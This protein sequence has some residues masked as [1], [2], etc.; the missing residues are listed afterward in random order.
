MRKIL[1]L[2]LVLSFL[3]PCFLIAQKKKLQFQSVNQFAITAGESHANTALQTVNGLKFLNYFTGI[4]V[5]LDYYRYK[6]VP[7]FFD[8]KWFYGENKNAFIYGDLG[9]NFPLKN[10]PEKNIGYYSDNKF[11]GG[12][13]T[14]IGIGYAV[15]L[16]KKISLQFTIGY[17]TK[18]LKIKT[19]SSYEC[20][21]APCPVDFSTYEYS[22]NRMILKAGLVF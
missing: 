4:G 12:L 10:T 17:S 15:S 8:G 9:Y 16:Y 18:N 7:L 14:D 21:V 11:A 20:L 22:F 2:I 13:Y 6:T 5:G 1:F 3:W 19:T